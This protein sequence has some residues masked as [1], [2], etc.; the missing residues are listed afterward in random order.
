METHLILTSFDICCLFILYL[1][2]LTFRVKIN[3]R[4]TTF[5]TEQ[6][7]FTSKLPIYLGLGLHF[8]INFIGIKFFFVQ[9]GLFIL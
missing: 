2:F 5:I 9:W 1:I 4:L 8:R 7:F 3:V 6:F